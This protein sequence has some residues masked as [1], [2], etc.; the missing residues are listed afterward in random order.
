MAAGPQDAPRHAGRVV[1]RVLLRRNIAVDAETAQ[2]VAAAVQ[3]ALQ[4]GAPSPPARHRPRA[5]ATGSEQLLISVEP[6][7]RCRSAAP[8]LLSRKMFSML[9]RCRYQCSTAAAGRGGHV[10]VG[11]DETAGVDS[12]FLL[13]LG[14]RQGPLVRVQG[15]AAPGPGVGG[16]L[17]GVQ[18][19]PADQQHGVFGPV[20]RLYGE[21]ATC[22][23][24][25]PIASRQASSAIP[26]SAFH[27]LVI[28]LA[29]IANAMFSFAAARASSPA[30]YP[31][32]AR[33]A[34]LRPAAR[35]PS[36]TACGSAASARPSSPATCERGSWSPDSRSAAS[37]I[38]VSAQDATCGRQAR[39]PW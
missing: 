38:S 8:C 18:L 26:A 12:G 4:A 20:R 16:D 11:A 27:M 19:D 3:A 14:E 7:G 15:A 9:V 39:C 24:C 36:R 1:R 21:T 30:K 22:A 31:A 17:I 25:M 33:S 6:D 28:R 37:G 5:P 29:P 10:H 32:S 34:I 13:Q 23:F 35:A 2:L